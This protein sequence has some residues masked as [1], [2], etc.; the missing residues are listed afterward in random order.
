[1][2]QKL[3]LGPAKVGGPIP[4]VPFK[5]HAAWRDQPSR[6]EFEIKV[7]ERYYAYGF[8]VTSKLVE[9]EWLV[10]I[11]QEADRRIFERKRGEIVLGDLDYANSDERDFLR[12]TAKGTPS[13]RLFLTECRERNVRGN[14]RGASGISALLN[15][16]EDVVTII[17]PETKLELL[18]FLATI[19]PQA[20]NLR[21][22]SPAILNAL[23]RE[24]ARS[25]ARA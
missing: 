24:S 19:A 10:E 1:M 12:F 16:F 8:S 3:V 2:A 21:A 6:F 23:T 15:W 20:E 17:F 5:L 14:L 13:N 9:E 4:C 22:S 11:N 25:L 18:R 7:D